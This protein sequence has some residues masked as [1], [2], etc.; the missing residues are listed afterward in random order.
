[1]KLLLCFLFCGCTSVNYPNGQ[2]LFT[3]SS[4]CQNVRIRAPDGM[5]VDIGV[6]DNAKVHREVGNS[7]FKAAPGV[8]A[9]IAGLL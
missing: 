5:T 1:M 9:A 4:D 8:G 7:V 3:A 2:R 6:I